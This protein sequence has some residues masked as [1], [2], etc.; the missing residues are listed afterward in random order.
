MEFLLDSVILIDHFNDITEATA[1]LADVEN[2]AAISVVTRAEVLTGFEADSSEEIE[3]LDE[4]P[5]LEITKPVA[6]LTA[7]LRREHGWKLP[8]AFQAALARHH[9]LKL[10]TR[11]TR[12]F[13]PERHGFVV[14][15]YALGT[16]N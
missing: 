11:N 16:E 1:Y 8:D 10:A 3:F 7:S 9:D 15:P 14:V 2:K 4:F 5:L 13:S 12:D 6:D